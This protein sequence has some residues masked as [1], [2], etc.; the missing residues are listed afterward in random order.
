MLLGIDVLLAL[1]ERGETAQTLSGTL[2][3]E[4][5]EVQRVLAMLKS[6][7]LVSVA[8]AGWGEP[9][10]GSIAVYVITPDGK[11]LYDRV[12]THFA[13]SLAWGEPMSGA[14]RFLLAV[15][16]DAQPAGRE[17]L[18]RVFDGLPE[19]DRTA[20]PQADALILGQAAV[21][22]ARRALE[23]SSETSAQAAGLASLGLGS[24]EE[25]GHVAGQLRE[26]SRVVGDAAVREVLEA[27]VGACEAAWQVRPLGARDPNTGSSRERAV[28]ESAYAEVAEHAARALQLLAGITGA[29]V[30]AEAEAVIARLVPGMPG[31]G[32]GERAGG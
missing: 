7:G 22:Y 27:A 29:S 6:N 31:R 26:Y 30:T 4:E 15:A 5:A 19:E 23:S 17:Q 18:L 16:N 8:T 11:R 25:L 3:F 12:L 28:D 20:R 1:H 24:V 21:S 9:Q 13:S 14:E 32:E 10:T 2:G